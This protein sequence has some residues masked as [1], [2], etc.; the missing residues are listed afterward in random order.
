M[1]FDVHCIFHRVGRGMS[2]SFFLL[3]LADGNEDLYA[4]FIGIA[5]KS[6]FLSKISS[7]SSYLTGK[8]VF[9]K[10]NLSMQPAS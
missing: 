7:E 6:A 8:H 10:S 1:C 3:V 5:R 2:V 4:L 9:F